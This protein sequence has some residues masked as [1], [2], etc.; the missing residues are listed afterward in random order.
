MSRGLPAL[1]VHPIVKVMPSACA[2]E[3]WKVKSVVNPLISTG[4][5]QNALPASLVKPLVN[6]KRLSSRSVE[7]LN[8]M[9]PGLLNP[10]PK[11]MEVVPLGSI[12]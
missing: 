7:P 10:M 6:C 3:S 9:Q 12:V 4:V 1:L 11:L 2:L 5:V 8:C